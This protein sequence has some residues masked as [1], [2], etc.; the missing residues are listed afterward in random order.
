M[1]RGLSSVSSIYYCSKLWRDH[2]N[3]FSVLSFVA[4]TS[5]TG[6]IY[7]VVPDLLSW[8][9]AR[10]NCRQ[11][12]KDLALIENAEDTAALQSLN[13]TGFS[14]IG[15]YRIPWNWSNKNNSTFRNFAVGKPDNAQGVNYCVAELPDHTWTDTP[16]TPNLAFFCHKGDSQKCSIKSKLW[17]NKMFNLFIGSLHVCQDKKLKTTLRI[18][19]WTE[20]NMTDPAMNTQL[21]Q[22]VKLFFSVSPSLKR[23]SQAENKYYCYTV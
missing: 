11:K 1:G 16:C 8:D 5:A 20:A 9:D 10:I 13:I 18:V 19:V 7:V 22:Q 4:D 14:W 2:R 21:L 12:Y 3:Y 17:L 15:L 23:Y 6:K